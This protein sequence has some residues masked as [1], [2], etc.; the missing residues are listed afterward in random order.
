VSAAADLAALS[1]GCLIRVSQ[2]SNG[3]QDAV[4]VERETRFIDDVSGNNATVALP[5]MASDQLMLFSLVVP[6][7]AQASGLMIDREPSLSGAA[8]AICTV[9]HVRKPRVAGRLGLMGKSAFTRNARADRIDCP[10]ARL[11]V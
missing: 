7:A 9:P 10:A 11:S 3:S 4:G 6:V 2:T 5:F 8:R 1:R